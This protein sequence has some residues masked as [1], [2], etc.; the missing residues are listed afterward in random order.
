MRRGLFALVLVAALSAVPAASAAPRSAP[1]VVSG[2]GGQAVVLTAPRGG[3]D[4][5]YPF[6][7]EPRLPGPDGAVSGVV[8]QRVRDSRLVGGLLLHNAPGFDRAI[9]IP[10]VDFEHTVLAAGRYRVTLL[11]TG[12]QTVHLAV[13]RA[14]ARRQ[15]VASGPPRP[16]TRVVASTSA[17]ASTW[18][19]RLGRVR[20]TD[21]VIAGAGSGG[22]LQQA[23]EDGLCVQPEGAATSPCLL[24][25]GLSLTPGAGSAGTWSAYLYRPGLLRPGSY[26]F[27][28]NAVGVGPASTTGHA[29]VVIALGR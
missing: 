6:F 17:F 8:I 11:G 4:V 12:K 15:L 7:T 22:D 26:V 3:L 5:E 18:S 1:L 9:P 28:G 20:T 13:R 23:S 29:A 2:L 19:D 25:G 14:S 10:L 21:Y 27:S 24:G 16:I